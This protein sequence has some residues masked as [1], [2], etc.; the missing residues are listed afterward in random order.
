MWNPIPEPAREGNQALQRE[1][2]ACLGEVVR[3]NK[4]PSAAFLHAVDVMREGIRRT[5]DEQWFAFG[6]KDLA[7]YIGSAY[8]DLLWRRFI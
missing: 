8:L 6:T 5:M 4:I 1:F 2:I 3:A 7:W